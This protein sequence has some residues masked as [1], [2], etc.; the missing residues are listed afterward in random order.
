MRTLVAEVHLGLERLEVV[1]DARLDLA[2]HLLPRPLLEA[3]EYPVDE[4]EGWLCCDCAVL[5][6]SKLVVVVAFVVVVVVVVDVGVEARLRGAVVIR[7]PNIGA[8]SL[9]I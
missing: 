4:H 6:Y 3:I 8:W 7:S 1:R 2:A 5:Y 9:L